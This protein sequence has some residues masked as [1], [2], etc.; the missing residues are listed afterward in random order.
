[1][2]LDFAILIDNSSMP[3]TCSGSHEAE[4]ITIKTFLVGYKAIAESQDGRIPICTTR[5]VSRHLPVP[6]IA[7]L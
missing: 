3:T 1:M 5:H 7:H 6:D 4:S 2:L